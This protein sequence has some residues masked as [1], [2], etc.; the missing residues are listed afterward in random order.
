MGTCHTKKLPPQEEEMMDDSVRDM[1]AAGVVKETTLP[2]QELV[3]SPVYTVAKKDTTAR[4]PVF[5]LRRVNHHLKEIHFKMAT[6]KDVKAAITKNCF[7]AKMDLK[8][9]FWGLPVHESDRKYLA[10]HWKG[11]II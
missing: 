11:K 4:R 2:N 5:N 3:R 6:M 7:M 8:D 10:F 1:L 9:C